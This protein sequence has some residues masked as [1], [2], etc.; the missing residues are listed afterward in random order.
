MN[1]SARLIALIVAVVAL[2][3]IVL[4][5]FHFYEKS[6]SQGAQ[7]RVN[8]GQQG[9]FQNSSVDAVSTISNAAANEAASDELTRKNEEDIRNAK[10]SSA[11][12]DPAARD[13]GLRALCLRGAYRDDPKCRVFKPNSR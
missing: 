7:S 3:L 2:I 11:A 9:A 12:V 13:A 1:L 10:G 6:R 4:A 5:A 8:A